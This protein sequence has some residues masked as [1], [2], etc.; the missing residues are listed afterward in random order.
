MPLRA[1]IDPMQLKSTLPD[2]FILEVNRH[3]DPVFRL[4]GTRVCAIMGR[5]LRGEDFTDLWHVTNRHKMRLAAGAVLANQA[6]LSVDVR[7]MA[8]DEQQGALEMLLMPLAS[9][10]GIC[11]RLFGSLVDLATPA[12][13]GERPRMLWAE[14]LNFIGSDQRL[15]ARQEAEAGRGTF[16]AVGT[17]AS[18]LRARIL[19]LTVLDGGRKD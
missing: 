2:V 11:D 13:L 14:S 1:D 9:R 5:E 10:P 12:L 6:P 18:S 16:A 15:T 7:S 4:A 17:P 19:R 8:D 3:G